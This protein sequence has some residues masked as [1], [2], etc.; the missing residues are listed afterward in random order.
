MTDQYPPMLIARVFHH[1]SASATLTREPLASCN[2]FVTVSSDTVWLWTH[3]SVANS[4][5]IKVHTCQFLWF[6]TL[7]LLDASEKEAWWQT[8][9][10]VK[11][12]SA[13][14]LFVLEKSASFVDLCLD[15]F[16]PVNMLITNQAA[17]Y[18]RRPP[19]PSRGMRKLYNVT[20][21]Y[22]GPIHPPG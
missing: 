10:I 17:F 5:K 4:I 6:Y 11:K 15:P 3:S 19:A 13:V 9:H 22:R 20:A 16:S 8:G 12:T 21:G 7:L 14:E 1:V 2:E 18:S